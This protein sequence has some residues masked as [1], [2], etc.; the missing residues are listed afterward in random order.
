MGTA[1]C[2][3]VLDG[4][5][6]QVSKMMQLRNTFQQLISQSN[7]FGKPWQ[8]LKNQLRLWDAST[9][10]VTRFIHIDHGIRHSEFVAKTAEKIWRVTCQNHPQWWTAEAAFLLNSSAYLHD[11]A[12]LVGYQQ[13][14]ALPE[15]CRA[16]IQPILR[17]YALDA[18]KAQEPL[19]YFLVRTNQGLLASAVI[20]ELASEGQIFHQLDSSIIAKLQFLVKF[21]NYLDTKEARTAAS[22]LRFTSP[23]IMLAAAAVLQI[24]DWAHLDRTRLNSAEFDAAVKES[25]RVITSLDSGGVPELPADGG[26]NGML[27]IFFRSH[28]VTKHTMRVFKSPEP[29]I[30]FAT[31][32]NLPNG[33]AASAKA[34]L[35][36]QWRAKFL[37]SR[38]RREIAYD[39]LREFCGVTLNYVEPRAETL[40][41]SK[42]KRKNR[43]YI[44]VPP[45]VSDFWSAQHWFT[46]AEDWRTLIRDGKLHANP[47]DEMSFSTS[48]EHVYT[49]CGGSLE[50]KST[51]LPR[52]SRRLFLLIHVKFTRGNPEL[53][54]AF[55]QALYHAI[56][57]PDH[58][59]ERNYGR[60][61]ETAIKHTKMKFCATLLQTLQIEDIETESRH[62]LRRISLSLQKNKSASKRTLK[63][64]LVNGGFD[65]LFDELFAKLIQHEIIIPK[66][67]R[68]FTCNKKS[69]LA[70]QF[71]LYGESFSQ[72]FQVYTQPQS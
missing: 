59:H 8:K 17:Q 16:I 37:P 52:L 66:T 57:C 10:F 64:N 20:N 34:T 5:C 7:Q 36:G 40:R 30:A 54:D 2:D 25:K 39:F 26:I 67:N 24:S 29:V 69:A 35:L 51:V 49:E 13:F 41:G 62:I 4:N 9:Q 46:L 33:L 22:K 44:P 63:A 61:I 21:Y 60:C 71:R 43:D 56:Y 42:K 32:V 14:N 23:D 15:K 12:M 18:N 68:K 72:S 6:F 47:F 31:Q 38:L 3:V 48:E 11:V 65:Q 28:Y 55:F 50:K 27:H 70:H 45:I 58:Q 19:S 53:A 1:G